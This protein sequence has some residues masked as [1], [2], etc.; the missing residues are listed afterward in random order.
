MKKHL[1]T[2]TLVSIIA[3]FATVCAAETF[4]FGYVDIQKAVTDSQAGKEAMEQFKTEVK[5]ME[6]D[7][8]G[9]KEQ[10][11]KLGEILEKQ[12]MMLTDGVRREKEKELLRRQRDYE[13]QLKD[14]KTELQIKEAELTN[15]ILE[16]LL[17]IIQK[18]GKGNNYTIIFEKSEKVLLYATEGLDL[19]DKIITLFDK[20][21]QKNKN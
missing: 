13:R 19:T 15:D 4:K 17:P 6:E 8:L 9:E 18:H 16:D 11:E 10:I 14:S 7:I 20:Q 12:S 1:I 2:V 21:Y 5:K 3:L